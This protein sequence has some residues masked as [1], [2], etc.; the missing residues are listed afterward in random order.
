MFPNKNVEIFHFTY[1]NVPTQSQNPQLYTHKKSKHHLHKKQFL[2]RIY[3]HLST[4]CVFSVL[5]SSEVLL[6]CS[7]SPVQS[8]SL[9]QFLQ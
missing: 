8:L 5:R 1:Y 6:G 7:P 2:Y 4:D 9:H 3:R